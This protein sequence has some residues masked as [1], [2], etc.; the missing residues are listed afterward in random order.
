MTIKEHVEAILNRSFKTL[1][2][3]YVSQKEGDANLRTS[4]LSRIIF[5]IKRE[6]SL[7]VCEQELRFVFVEQ[8]NIEIEQGWDVFYSVETPTEY[9]YSGFSSG[10]PKCD[11]N[12]RSGA[13]DLVIH[14]NALKRVALLEFK[15]HDA[16]KGDYKKDFCKLE[17]EKR[18]C[19]FFVNI[20]EN[21]TKSTF[22]SVHEKIKDHLHGNIC[23]R[24]WSLGLGKDVTKEIIEYK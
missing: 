19:V 14:D 22:R 24:F 7:R 6:E 10:N 17:S 8:L 15:A 20:L 4:R 1:Q 11:I 5:P 12:G 9:A 2:A 3:V 21:V 16:K 23:F 18:D 13:F